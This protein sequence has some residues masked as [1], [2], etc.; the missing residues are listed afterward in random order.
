MASLVPYSSSLGNAYAKHLLRRSTFKYTQ[1]LINQFAVLTPTQALD[2]LL[3]SDP[4]T[5]NFPYDPLPTTAPEGFWTE[6]TNFD[7]TSGHT[8]K[9]SIISGWWWYNAIN[10]ATLK[11]KISHFLSTC[12]T[13]E[14]SNG[15]GTPSEFYDHLRLLL[16]Y[17]YGNYKT[18]AIKMTLDNS[19]LNYLNNTTNT[20]NS[21]N[22][23]YARE[24]LE[25]FTIGKGPQISAGNYT[26]YTENDIVE[27]AKVLTG[28]KRKNDRSVID[29]NT[30][31][32]KG[33]NVFSSHHLSA[34][35]FSSAFDSVVI[36]AASDANGMDAELSAFV[37]MIF[38]KTAT[39]QNI[40]RKIYRYFVKTT[41]TAEVET[42]IILPLAQDLY[43]NG[44]EIVPII[45][46]LL[47]S[48]HFYDLD[49][50]NATDETIGG[51]IKSPLQQISEV[52]SFLQ[53]TIPNPT[54]QPFEF[55]YKFWHL[56]AHNTFLTGANMALFDPQS[57]AGHPAYYQSPDFDKYWIS[58]STLIAKYRLGESLLDGVNRITG[59]SNIYAII[60]I[61][62]VIK[63][64]NIVSVANDPIILTKE[65]C[66]AL[67]GQ[68]TDLDRS[69][70]FMNT[71]LLQGLAT[72]YWTTAWNDY[73][74]T[75]DKSVVEPRLKALLTNIL[76]AP[77]SQ[78][79]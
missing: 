20:K 36:N 54:L 23:N 48:Q 8:R 67:F 52:C 59:N 11:Y 65:L 14:K 9:V 5:I 68:T 6:S 38:N 2:L 57:V 24:F 53:I 62:L 61:C 33:Y 4:L 45:R 79:F 42:D 60:D 74:N 39:A 17:S 55:Y 21:P 15:I 58:A 7:S 69:N 40:C 72:Y 29:T 1:D 51:I 71:F 75:N 10:S 77:E 34:K 63:N 27:A 19:M 56:F 28:F 50:S 31:L 78:I 66:D 46:R 3:V 35:T 49:D 18:L 30:L 76:R 64:S 37:T 44:Y 13:V 41:I 43:T 26:T 22:E 12:F 32:P 73:I 25:L 70:Y 16:Y 47:Q